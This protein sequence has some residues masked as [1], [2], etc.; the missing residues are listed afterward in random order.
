VCRI[1]FSC[2][3]VEGFNTVVVSGGVGIGWFRSWSVESKEFKFSIKDGSS[4]LTIQE[5][6]RGVQRAVNLRKKEQVWLARIFSELV[7]VEDSRVFS[8]Q[9]APGHPRVLAQKCGNRN[10]RFLVLEEYNDRGRCGSIFVPEGRDR[11]GWNR[12]IEELQLVIQTPVHSWEIP[13]EKKKGTRRCCLERQ[14]RDCRIRWW[15]RRE[16]KGRF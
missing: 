14:R 12:F 3:N 11:Q 8:D 15:L 10:G 7:A 13:K 4:V 5:K 16:L 6:R 2:N 9:T 1:F